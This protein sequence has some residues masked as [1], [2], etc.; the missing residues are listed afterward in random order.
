MQDNSSI[1]GA[2]PLRSRATTDGRIGN[3]NG[4]SAPEPWQCAPWRPPP[5]ATPCPRLRAAHPA[6][7]APLMLDTRRRMG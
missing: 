6:P 3:S 2:R 4:I 1:S 7:S 5:A